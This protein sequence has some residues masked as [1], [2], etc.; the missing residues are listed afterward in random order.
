MTKIYVPITDEEFVMLSQKAF[1]NCRHPREQARHFIRQ[2]L[3]LVD[4]GP[5]LETNNRHA[6]TLTET[7]SK[8]V[9]RNP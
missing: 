2:A 6:V 8:A 4:D 5:S 9:G 3:G 1:R 7:T